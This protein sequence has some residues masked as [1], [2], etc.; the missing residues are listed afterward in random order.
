MAIEFEES[1]ADK[2]I[3]GLEHQ[4]KDAGRYVAERLRRN[5]YRYLEAGDDIWAEPLID[6]MTGIRTTPSHSEFTI[7]HPAAALHEYGGSIEAV[8]EV[9]VE[10]MAFSWDADQLREARETIPDEYFQK[11]G[12][13]MIPP[14]RY[15]NNAVIRTRQEVE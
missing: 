15:L 1:V 8:T 6:S 14:K 10:N 2:I 5:T 12:P 13:F 3:Q 11:N 4:K 9:E 7:D